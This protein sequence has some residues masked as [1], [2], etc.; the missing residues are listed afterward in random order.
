M[1]TL[2]FTKITAVVLTTLLWACSTATAQLTVA[3]PAR[4]IQIRTID[5][6]NQTVEVHNF[7]L[8]DQVLDGWRFCTHDESAVRRY[9]SP[10]GFNGVPLAAGESIF[11]MYNNDAVAPNEFNIAGLG[12]FALPLDTDGAYSIQFYFQTPFGIG[13]NIADH[14]QFSLNGSDDETADERSDEA[15]VGGL[16]TDENLWIPVSASTTSISLIAGAEFNELNSPLDYDVVTPALASIEIVNNELV[17]RATQ[18]PDDIVVTQSD[19]LMSVVVNDTQSESFPLESITSID[20]FGFG[21]ADTIDADVSVPTFVSGGFGADTITG[22]SNENDIFGGPGADVIFGGPMDDFINSG[23]GQDTVNAL[24]G[25][26]V[27]LGGD[28]SDTL[29]AGPGD[30]IVTAGLGADTVNAG[31]GDDIVC[32]NAGADTLIGGPGNDELTG[33][34]G[35]DELIGGGGNDILNGG[36][37]RDILDGSAGIDTAIDVGEVEISIELRSGT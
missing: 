21:G 14:L 37:A 29:I 23:R 30:D 7:G 6:A 5:L 19:D 18:G 10:G 28:A 12:N 24:G 16:W 1:L 20:I 2:N 27:I 36:E 35:P 8:T 3:N 32:G 25:N 15:V 9:S 4:D 11:L 33:V 26:D 13:A 22:G 31:A 17:I 34:G